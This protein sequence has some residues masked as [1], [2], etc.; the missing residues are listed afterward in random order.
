ME[1]YRLIFTRRAKK[2]LYLINASEYKEKVYKILALLEYNP[3]KSPPFYERLHGDLKDAFSRRINQQH[4][5]VYQ[6][7]EDVKTVKI[8][9]MWTHYQ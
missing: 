2:D 6:V 4:R 5:L 3:F 1:K 7:F 9:M 8:L